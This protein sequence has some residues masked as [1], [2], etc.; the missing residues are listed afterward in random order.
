MTPLRLCLSVTFHDAAF[1]GRRD[2]GAS[3]W[4]P[5]PLRAFQALLAA[6]A[7]FWRDEKFDTHAQPA[8]EWLESLAP[9][10]IVAPIGR[11][12]LSPYRLYVPN[13]AGDLVAKAWAAGNT[14]A[15]IATHRTGKDV[16]PTR[17][18]GGDAFTGGNTVRFLWQLSESLPEKVSEFIAS[19]SAAAR[20]LT[21]VGWG[22]DMAAGHAGLVDQRE[23]SEF[24]SD[25]RWERWTPCHVGTPLRVPQPETIQ[26]P[27]TFRSL[28][29]RHASF[30]RRMSGGGPQEVPSFTAF[31]VVCYRRAADPPPRSFFSFNLLKPDA[32]GFRP[33][34]PARQAMAVAAMIRH[35]ASTGQMSH[36]LGWSPEKVAGFVLG[37]GETPGQTHRPVEGPRLAYLPLPSIEPRGGGRGEVVASIRRALITVF[38]EDATEDL[39]HLARLLSGSDLIGVKSL[40]A[41]AMLSQ[42]LRPDGTVAR[43]V[44]PSSTWATVTPVI[45]PGYD[46]PRK[47]R[48]RLFQETEKGGPRPGPEEQKELLNKLDR[49]IDHLL[50]KSIRQ[51]GYSEE[52]A[53]HAAIEW[54]TVGY[55]PGTEPATHYDFPKHL[56]RFRRLHVRFTWRDGNGNSIPLPGPICLGGGRFYGLGLF[57]TVR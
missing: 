40:D 11:T 17:L 43:Y 6:S 41:I 12:A 32:T 18:V 36:S 31:R 34:D 16:R 15:S 4:P 26:G 25:Q 52:L 24:S 28:V 19:L 51:A 46:D 53:R 49:R 1:H 56:R 30:T 55:L 20:S 37:H 33:F 35:A 9:P 23:V 7:A 27:S 54:R 2:N 22:I 10:E 29:T 47:V 48:K 44:D 39:R 3:E 38:N 14:D 21:H 42:I 8:L 45:L 13:N 5:S 50:R 57:A